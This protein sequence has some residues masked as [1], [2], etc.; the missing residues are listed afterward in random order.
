MPDYS[1]LYVPAGTYLMTGPVH[2]RKPLTI[3]GAG[4]TSVTFV[5]PRGWGWSNG[6][7][8]ITGDALFS[9]W[10]SL[11]GSLKITDLTPGAPRGTNA[12]QVGTRSDGFHAA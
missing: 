8:G 3:K 12:V 5:V 2:I 1:V 9:F 10:G 6:M 11:R 4:S 7:N